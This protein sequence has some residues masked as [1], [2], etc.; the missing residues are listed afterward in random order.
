MTYIANVGGERRVSLPTPPDWSEIKNRSLGEIRC[1]ECDEPLIAKGGPTF[2]VRPH[3]AHYPDSTCVLKSSGETPYHDLAKALIVKTALEFGCQVFYEKQVSR[4]GITIQP[5]V[6]IIRPDGTQ[7]AFEVQHSSQTAAEYVRRSEHYRDVDIPVVWLTWSKFLDK[8]GHLHDDVDIIFIEGLAWADTDHKGVPPL[9][10]FLKIGYQGVRGMFCV[11]DGQQQRRLVVD[12]RVSSQD[13]RDRW[14]DCAGICETND[15]RNPMFMDFTRGIEVTHR[16]SSIYAKEMPFENISATVSVVR[17]GPFERVLHK[18]CA[19]EGQLSQAWLDAYREVTILWEGLE[20]GWDAYE[21]RLGAYQR[22]IEAERAA[23]EAE[24]EKDRQIREMQA[25]WEQKAAEAERLR[26]EHESLEPQLRK[27]Y[28]KRAYENLS[29]VLTLAH[30]MEAQYSFLRGFSRRFTDEDNL[31]G[32]LSHLLQTAITSFDDIT[33]AQWRMFAGDM[34]H[35]ADFMKRFG[36]VV[37]PN[38]QIHYSNI[39]KLY[40]Q[41]EKG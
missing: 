14:F 19:G 33:S 28:R 4:D 1:T 16:Y 8:L 22:R 24:A 37:Y 15:E 35:P 40:T 6:R 31:K 36:Q 27:W 34:M 39:I 20:A 2:D 5:D 11:P 32:Y 21:V 38:H 23:A 41:S 29:E 10:L 17:I 26:E 18:L 3:F 12:N 13:W 25:R 9:E 7:L 30:A